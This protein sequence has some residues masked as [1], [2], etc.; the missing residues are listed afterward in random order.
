MIQADIPLRDIFYWIIPFLVAMLFA[1]T[2]INI[3]PILSTWLPA[4]YG[5]M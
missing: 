2:I 4:L 3:F 1:M 5:L